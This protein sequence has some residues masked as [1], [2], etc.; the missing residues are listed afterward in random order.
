MRVEVC[1]VFLLLSLLLKSATT[2]FTSCSSLT[3]L[4]FVIFLIMSLKCITTYFTFCPWLTN[5]CRCSY[6][7]LFSLFVFPFLS[8]SLYNYTHFNNCRFYPLCCY[9]LIWPIQMMQKTLKMTETRAYRYSSESYS[10]KAMRWIP[11]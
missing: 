7:I 10:A 5:M 6:A 1:R 9:W 11:T 3:N 8:F 2:H 4:Y